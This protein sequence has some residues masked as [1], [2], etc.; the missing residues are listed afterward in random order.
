[1]AFI[2]TGEIFICGYICR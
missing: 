1:M 2:K